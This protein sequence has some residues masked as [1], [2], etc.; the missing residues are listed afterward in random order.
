MREPRAVDADALHLAAGMAGFVGRVVETVLERRRAAVDDEDLLG[1]LALELEAVGII[2]LVQRGGRL[3]R[4][5]QDRLHP[6]GD[7]SRDVL[8]RARLGHDDGLK[9]RHG[10]QQHLAARLGDEIREHRVAGHQRHLVERV[11]GLAIG[12]AT[13]AR[14]RRR[15]T[16]TSIVPLRTTPKCVASSP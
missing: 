11:A 16:E 1:P 6:L 13:A 15:A 10:N 2:A 14:R 4:I 3:A 7:G 5:G 9:Q 8:H 12:R